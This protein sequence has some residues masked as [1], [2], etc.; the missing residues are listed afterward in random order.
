MVGLRRQS[1]LLV[2]RNASLG[3]HAFCVSRPLR[4]A[5]ANS[6]GNS[7]A[8]QHLMQGVLLNGGG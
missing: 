5:N 3:V 7:L 4:P 1:R 6:I 8:R 2:S